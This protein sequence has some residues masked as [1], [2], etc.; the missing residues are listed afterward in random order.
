MK[1]LVPLVALVMGL[2]ACAGAGPP[3]SHSRASATPAPGA[4]ASP[5]PAAAEPLFAVFE[6]PGRGDEVDIV[7]IVGLDGYVRVK[8][9]FQFCRGSYV[10]MNVMMLQSE[11]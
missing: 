4:K 8:V 3:E 1:I 7:V 9:K 2:T 11:V 10:F 5:A 6:S